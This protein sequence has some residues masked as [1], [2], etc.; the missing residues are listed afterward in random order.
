MKSKEIND[1]AKEQKANDNIEQPTAYNTLFPIVG[2]GGGKGSLTALEQFFKHMPAQSG[3]GFVFV[4]HQDA[5]DMPD[6]V[7]LIKSYTTIPVVEAQDGV[8]VQPDHIYVSPCGVDT[9]I[10]QGKLLLFQPAADRSTQMCIDHF[11]QS[12]A[13]DQGKRAVGII[14]SGCGVDGETGIRMI[15]EQFGLTLAQ[16]PLTAELPN[17]PI[18]S[19][20]TQM[21]DYILPVDEMPRKLVQYLSH[22]ALL[23]SEDDGEVQDQADNSIY[24]QKILLLLRSN[25]GHDFSL[26]KTNTIFRRI[27]RRIAFHRLQHYEDYVN[28]LR[29]NPTEIETLLNELLIGVTK[30]F[31]DRK[32]F[33]VLKKQIH[34]LLTH[35]KQDE[36]I[37][38]WIAG[39]STGEEA[40]SIAILVSEFLE[41][42]KQKRKPRVQIFAT[43]LDANAIEHARSGFYSGNIASELTAWQLE[44]FFIKKSDGYV[45]KKE[46]RELIVFAQH[47]L[48]KDAP[49]TRLDMLCCRNVMIYLT[50]ELQKKILP[51][52]HYS[53]LSGG[54]LFLGPAESV[55]TFHEMFDV[56]DSKWK[57]FKRKEGISTVGKFLDFPFHVGNND[58]VIAAK[59]NPPRKI[60]PLAEDFNHLLLEKHTPA[61]LL[62]ND[63]GEILYVNGQTNRYIQLQAGEAVMNIHRMIREELKYVLG[64]ALHQAS[65]SKQRVEVKD[66][67]IKEGS[68]LHLVSFAVDYLEESSLHGLLMVSFSEQYAH[69]QT[70]EANAKANISEA[71]IDDLQKELIYTKQQLHQTIEQMEISLEEL[72]STNEELQSTNEELQ[73]TNEE[74]L[75]TREEMQTLNEQLMTVNLQYQKKAEELTVL[76][77]DLKNLHDSTE[78]G[79]VF[80]DV[81]LHILRYTPQAGKLLRITL[82]DI[83]SSAVNFLAKFGLA[84]LPELINTVIETLHTKTIELRHQDGDW[85]AVRIAAYRT[86][87]NFISG[88]VLTFSNI[89]RE[90]NLGL[91]YAAL[92]GFTQKVIDADGAAVALLYPNKQLLAYN[93]AFQRLFPLV[94]AENLELSFDEIVQRTWD[95]E[96]ISERL[97]TMG[98]V[99]EEINIAYRKNGTD[100]KFL[101]SVE[102]IFIDGADQIIMYVKFEQK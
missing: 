20:K 48:V 1:T 39:C 102:R 14:L 87:D 77:N 53:L 63:R 80:L 57:I 42:S 37:R 31:R 23:F 18:A 72:K 38:I 44:R 46:I 32:A 83:G 90:K 85:Y 58:K 26:Y 54:I 19:V 51:I 41:A 43:D 12:L 7:N 4:F 73:S 35:K 88:A 98:K 55:G 99:D 49:F 96:N 66:V 9:G 47:N 25:T 68:A 62:L 11:F 50:A 86:L 36:P 10:H 16:E 101:V 84:D 34:S 30:F 79:T 76:Q 78:D 27:D 92:S 15:K 60:N 52:F 28:Y 2:I 71:A 64:N 61:S 69:E 81:Q 94:K 95:A 5:A 29:E 40:Y 91:R 97:A 89:T 93:H 82:E 70:K 33:D 13:E 6:F 74:A 65:S 67:K 21:V 8:I 17:M 22:P 56:L 3:M 100:N 45:V 24:I 59:K 75:T